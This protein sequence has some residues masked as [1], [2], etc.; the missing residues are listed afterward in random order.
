[1]SGKKLNNESVLV[2]AM[3][4]KITENKQKLIPI[5]KTIIF[6]GLQ[7]ILLWVL[8][9]DSSI[10]YDENEDSNNSIMK[11]KGNFKFCYNSELT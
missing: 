9:D 5:I 4:H 6:C 2:S 1:M 7:N 11:Q 3:V 10:Y 8:R